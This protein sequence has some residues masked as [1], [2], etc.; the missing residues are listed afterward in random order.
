MVNTLAML[1]KDATPLR[2]VSGIDDILEGMKMWRLWSA[3]AW[4]DIRTTYRRSFL[5]VAWV[6]ISF[7]AFIIAKLIIFGSLLGQGGDMKSF[8]LYLAFGFLVWQLISNIVSAGTT[9]FVSSEGWIKSDPLPIS[10]YAYQSVA[11]CFFNY[12]LTALATAGLMIYAQ[13]PVTNKFWLILPVQIVLIVNAMWVQLLLGIICTRFRDITHLITT[14]MRI[15]FFLT[16]IFW[17]PEQLGEEVMKYLWWNPFYHFI[18]IL[19]APVLEGELALESWQFVGV[20]TVLGWGIALITFSRF[21]KRIAF[22]F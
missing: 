21:R 3:L 8:A 13:V 22:W 6:G 4:E 14:V 18:E 11:R 7:A 5:G 10:L 17:R 9:V 15:A 19:R 12:G 16:P 2:L 20:V 1:H